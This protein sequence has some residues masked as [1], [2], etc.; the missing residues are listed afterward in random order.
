MPSQILSSSSGSALILRL[1]NICLNKSFPMYTFRC[2]A[3]VC[4]FI[5]AVSLPA[6][7]ACAHLFVCACVCLCV[8]LC[9]RVCVSAIALVPLNILIPS[10]SCFSCFDLKLLHLFESRNESSYTSRS[11]RTSDFNPVSNVGFHNSIAQAGG[12]VNKIAQKRECMRRWIFCAHNE[13]LLIR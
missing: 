2:V 9:L 5:T 7:C 1:D 8:C 3:D 13:C 6:V 11:K 4:G 10:L 12:S